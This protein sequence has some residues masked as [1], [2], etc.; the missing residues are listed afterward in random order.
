MGSEQ[1]WKRLIPPVKI[2]SLMDEQKDESFMY[3]IE[4]GPGVESFSSLKF[5][6]MV[7]LLIMMILINGLC[8]L[9]HKPAKHC[10]EVSV[11]KDLSFIHHLYQLYEQFSHDI[12]WNKSPITFRAAAWRQMLTHSYVH[13]ERLYFNTQW[14]KHHFWFYRIFSL[15]SI[16]NAF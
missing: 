5:L 2:M 15:N 3:F 1:K 8:N 9:S 13:H 6:K 12:E 10:F 16:W 7:K 4:G 11:C 14:K